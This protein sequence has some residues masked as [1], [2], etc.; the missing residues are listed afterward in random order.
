MGIFHRQG[1]LSFASRSVII[2][3]QAR[4]LLCGTKPGLVVAGQRP[5]AGVRD[6]NLRGTSTANSEPQIAHAWVSV[7]GH[8]SGLGHHG[9][10]RENIVSTTILKG[11]NP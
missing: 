3:Q 8:K 1:C 2:L 4:R 7:E 6:S 11:S 10:M 9:H 5:V